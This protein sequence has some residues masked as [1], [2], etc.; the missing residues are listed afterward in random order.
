VEEPSSTLLARVQAENPQAW[1]RLVH[2]YGPLVHSWCQRARL[3]EAD[4]ADVGQEVFQAVFRSIKNFQRQRG[5]FCGWLRTIVQSKIVDFRR[6]MQPGAE[7]MGGSDANT[8]LQELPDRDLEEAELTPTEELELCRRAIDLVLSG[9]EEQTR[10]AFLRVAAGGQDAEE[11]ARDLG[12]SVNAVYL[13]QSR[14][15]RR[16]REEFEGLLDL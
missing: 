8:K 2:L 15:K 7:G 13:A 10:Q 5:T 9:C 4:A 14:L 1:D 11:V 12:M 16:I 6:R 3:R